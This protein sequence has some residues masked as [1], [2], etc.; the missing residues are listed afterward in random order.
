MNDNLASTT[1]VTMDEGD[2]KFPPM[3]LLHLHESAY[4]IFFPYK[5]NIVLLLVLL[6]LMTGPR[7]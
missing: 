2:N 4:L 7:L 3:G 5:V 6:Y 1:E